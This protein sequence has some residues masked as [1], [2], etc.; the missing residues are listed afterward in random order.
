MQ[1]VN[2]YVQQADR[3]SKKKNP[4]IKIVVDEQTASNYLH[5]GEPK[6]IGFLIHIDHAEWKRV[7]REIEFE[8]SLQESSLKSGSTVATK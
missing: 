8:K 5:F 4:T 6:E 1:I 3:G 2:G 7:D